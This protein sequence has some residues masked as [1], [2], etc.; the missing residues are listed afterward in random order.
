MCCLMIKRR[1][2][3]APA[4]SPATADGS[5][6]EDSGVDALVEDTV[7]RRPAAVAMRRPAGVGM[8][9]PAAA[10]AASPAASDGS[11]HDD[12]GTDVSS[13]MDP[14]KATGCYKCRYRKGCGQCRAWAAEGEKG[15]YLNDYGIVCR[16]PAN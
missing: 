2:V 10:P 15:R 16:E 3:I 13:D 7:M 14:D 8:R 6:H 4:A 9:R 1:P 12:S 11:A 5:A